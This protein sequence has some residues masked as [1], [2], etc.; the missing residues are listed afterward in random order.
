LVEQGIP[1]EKV[2]PV[3]GEFRQV[4][5]VVRAAFQ[6][7][8]ERDVRRVLLAGKAFFCRR[9]LLLASY[10][11]SLGMEIDI[12]PL[13]DH[14]GITSGSWFLSEVGIQR[15]LKEVEACAAI[16]WQLNEERAGKF[17]PSIC[18]T[19][20]KKGEGDPD[21]RTGIDSDCG[22]GNFASDL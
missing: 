13:N 7:L 8:A 11:A 17:N 18:Q 12:L 4:R 19:H 2:E 10:F 16:L 15:V 21:E 5:D 9:F 3:R 6:L 20:S 1:H 14:R 22:P